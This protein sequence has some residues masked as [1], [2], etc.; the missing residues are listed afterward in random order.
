VTA[1]EP[2]RQRWEPR[3]RSEL[4]SVF[5]PKAWSVSQSYLILDIETVLDAELPIVPVADNERLPAPP[6]HRVVVI[7][8]LL[9]DPNYEVKR[10]GVVGDA[11]DEAGMLRDFAKLLDDR[12]PTLVTFNGRSF[13]MPVIATRCLRHGIP[14][15]HYYRSRDV[16]Y[17]FTA[18]GHLDLMDYVADFGAAKASRLDV[19]A[20]LCGM[21]GK[22]G[23]EGKDVGPMVHA[24][25]LQEVRDYCLCDVA[26]TAGVF[27]RV[28]L[29][30]GELEREPYLRGMRSLLTLIRSDP[31]LSPVAAALN[32]SR[33]LLDT[34]I[35]APETTVAS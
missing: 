20:K 6:H 33:L 22:V 15:R 24:G 11:K 9:L 32:E 30:R 4:L 1:R 10:L 12:R 31:R 21:P 34:D 18:E 17:R 25:R 26:Q 23:I 3:P 29:L 14:L 19:I 28:Q 13:D 16:R 8:A 35:A 27:L 5:H 7:G 2:N